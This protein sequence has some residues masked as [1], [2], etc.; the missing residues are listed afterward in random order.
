M[1]ALA[2]AASP[3]ESLPP[4]ALYSGSLAKV[5]LADVLQTLWVDKKT[6]TLGITT[7]AGAGDVRLLLGAV[8]DVTVNGRAIVVTLERGV[9]LRFFA[10]AASWRLLEA[11]LRTGDL[12]FEDP[13]LGL[14]RLA[15]ILGT[16]REH[17]DA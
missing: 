3:R 8:V 4:S 7:P 11:H 12:T 6:G 9:E 5:S 10:D 13:E 2:A 1:N 17:L 14:R 16:H 15:E